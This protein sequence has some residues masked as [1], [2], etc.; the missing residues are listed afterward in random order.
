MDDMTNRLS[1][2]WILDFEKQIIRGK[3]VLLYGNVHDQFLWNDVYYTAGEFLKSYFTDKGFDIVV[4]YDIIDGFRFAADGMRERFEEIRRQRIQEVHVGVSGSNAPSPSALPRVDSPGTASDRSR[5]M[6]VAGQP[7]RTVPPREAFSILR[8]VLAQS[9]VPVVSIID[10]GDLLTSDASRYVDSERDALAFLKKCSFEAAIVRQGDLA[11]YRNTLV[12]TADNLN[13]VPEWLYRDNPFVSLVQAAR[14][15]KDERKQFAVSFAR[16]SERSQGFCGGNDIPSCDFEQICDEFAD[17]TDGFQ[18]WDLESLRR[19]SWVESMPIAESRKLIDFFKFGLRDDPW[20]KLNSDK[21]RDAKE[22]LSSQVIGQPR[23]V[24]AVTTMLTSA[25]VGLSMT[26]S[27][28]MGGRPKGIFFFVGPT[29]VGKT[30]LAKALTKLVFGDEKAFARF[31]MSEYKEE[32]AAEKLAGAPPG[33]VGYEEGGQLTNRVME[34]P[35]SILLFDEIEKAHPKVLDKFLQILEDGRLTDGKGQT[36]YFNQTAI[37]FTSNIGASDLTDPHSGAVIRKGIMRQVSLDEVASIPYEEVEKHFRTEVE[38]YF[39]SRIGRAELLNRLGDNIIVFD[40]L[41][42][43]HV[44]A[45]ALK[46]LNK[47]AANA[48]EKYGLALS[49]APSVLDYL[50]TIMSSGDNLLY[51]GRRV[52]TTLETI[53]ERPLNRYLFENNPDSSLTENHRLELGICSDGML[54]VR[55]V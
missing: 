35:H 39:S 7:S 28:G 4:T 5:P 6:A 51:G 55:S 27:A 24:D 16:Q 15:N 33:F 2:R 1:S 36:A 42:P 34:H 32:H 13:R 23:A 50:S 43:E 46:F 26:T 12:V 37:I 47:L 54:E 29:G 22:I 17:L 52:K 53:V 18:A 3:H 30:E 20:E 38:W 8:L 40:V 49:Y 10:L 31:D 19:T 45:I 14:P 48:C 21:V 44:S 11:G 41:R 9:S 25:R